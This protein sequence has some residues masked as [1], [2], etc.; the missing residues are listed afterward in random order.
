MPQSKTKRKK[1]QRSDSKGE[2]SPSWG[3]AAPKSTRSTNLALGLM[4]VLFIGG[5]ALYWILTQ[6]QESDFLDLA[7]QGQTGLDAVGEL[8]R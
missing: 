2:R 5:G 7:A 4:A 6:A 3:G 8:S 1:T